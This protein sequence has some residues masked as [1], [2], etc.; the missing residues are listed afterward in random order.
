MTEQTLTRQRD[1]T[2]LEARI[3]ANAQSQT[4]DLA[5]WIVVNANIPLG[6]SILELCAG[7][8]AQTR[9]LLRAVGS[10]GIVVGVD[11]S[12]EA[13]DSLL[14]SVAPED[15]GRLRLI[16]EEMEHMAS[17]LGEL[18]LC[19]GTFD[20]AFCSYGLYYSRD[21]L[22]TLREMKSWLKDE[23]KIVVVGPFGPNNRQLFQLLE[24][25]GVTIPDLVRF[26]S[27]RFM[28]DVVI[29]FGAEQFHQVNVRTLV[30][31]VLW[32]EAD[33]VLTYWEHSTFYDAR[34]RPG[35]ATALNCH[36]DSHGIFVNEKWV[37]L[38]EMSE[39]RS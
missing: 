38:I 33:E 9:H 2:S 6:G 21:P 34:R 12:R 11:V 36:F 37:A 29:P 14:E 23:G 15:R 30:N 8:G 20:V 22:N 16:A 1:A 35:V 7:T 28:L 32:H 18:G 10:G 13:L 5:Q 31:P 3:Q 25:Q 26:T 24:S 39:A 17:P 4:T 19:T 27:D